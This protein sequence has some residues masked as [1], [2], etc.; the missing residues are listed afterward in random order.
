MFH[1]VPASVTDGYSFSAQ[2]ARVCVCVR[3]HITTALLEGFELTN[4][5]EAEPLR[6]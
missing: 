1:G 2:N 4:C 5:H 3:V 6:S